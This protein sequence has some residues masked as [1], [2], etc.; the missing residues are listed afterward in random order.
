MAVAIP[1]TIMYCNFLWIAFAMLIALVWAVADR[2]RP[3]YQQVKYWARIVFRYYLALTLFVYGF[4]KIIKLQFPFPGL[5]RLTQPYG[6]SSPM[7]LAWTFLGYS[8]GYNYFTGG[9]EV[10]AGCLLFFKRTTLAGSLLAIAV[11]ANIFAMNLA[12]DIPVKIFAANLLLLAGWLAWHDINR[13]VNVFFLNK[14][15]AAAYL[16]M[17][18]Q[19]R[20]KKIFQSSL[21][22]LA[23]IFTFYTTLG[24]ALKAEKEYGEK[25][26]KPPLYGIYDTQ[27]FIQKGDTLPPLSTDS[28]RWK[29]MIINYPEHAYVYAMTDSLTNMIMTV[30]T[31]KKTARFISYKDSTVRFNFSLS[32]GG[33]KPVVAQR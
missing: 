13:L 17:P 31:I 11:M 7:G 26:P 5:F 1:L 12:Y 15:A 25:A 14:P 29:R 10:L 23:I 8:K 6:D 3:S 9:A 32:A 20:W 24:S 2:K 19:T 30:D 28:V 22:A 18:L 27:L 4:D 33:F 16:G 21:K